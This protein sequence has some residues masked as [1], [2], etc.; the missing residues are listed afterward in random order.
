M[1]YSRQFARSQWRKSFLN[2]I[3]FATT[4]QPGRANSFRT[5]TGRCKS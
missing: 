3:V 2:N 5:F 4:R 1:K